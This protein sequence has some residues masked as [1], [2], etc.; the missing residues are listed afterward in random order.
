MISDQ[1]VPVPS[2][3]F[4]KNGVPIKIITAATKTSQ[5]IAEAID[6]IIKSQSLTAAGASQQ[7]IA[8]ESTVGTSE[9][10]K[11]E[12]PKASN[13]PEEAEIIFEGDVCYRKEKSS[14]EASGSKEVTSEDPITPEETEDQRQEKIK[15]A[16]KLI[17]EKRI[18]RVK[19][20]QRLEKEREVQ[21]RKDGKEFVKMQKWQD[22]EEFKNLQEERKRDKAEAK[23]ARQ[24]VL[25]QIEQDKQERA[26]R[27]LMSQPT[28]ADQLANEQTKK[29][30]A[31]APMVTPPNSTKIQFKLPNGDSEIVTFESIMLFA[32][33]HAYVKSD[34][35]QGSGIKDFTL[36]TTFPRREFTSADFDKTLLDLNLVPSSVILVIPSKGKTTSNNFNPSTILP[37]QTDGSFI[38]MITAL[39]MGLFSPVFT[40]FAYVGRILTGNRDNAEGVTVESEVGKRKRNEDILTPNDAAKKRNLS[41]F[42]QQSQDGET[43]SSSGAIP[44]TG[45]YNRGNPSSNIHRL[46]QDSESDDEDRK[47]W[48]GNSTQQM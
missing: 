30:P 36:A 41:A 6:L 38:D 46:H 7:F 33:V 44:K 1:L 39:F 18:A 4:I 43:S 13:Q 16:L 2:L 12:D 37:T 9:D 17:E 35:L 48:N 20:E 42:N 32:D 24:R 34:I 21:R 47:T 11:K 28:A 19:E 25:D 40:L 31:P 45:A 5:E 22:E 26:Q 23:A 8:A 27:F 29:T 15:H 3:F 14:D 10:V